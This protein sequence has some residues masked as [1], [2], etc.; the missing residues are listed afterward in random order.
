MIE[1]AAL[2]F[3]LGARIDDRRLEGATAE[4]NDLPVAGV[5]AR[6]MDERA[7]DLDGLAS[8]IERAGNRNFV[9]AAVDR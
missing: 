5:G 1:A 6:K 7:G 9:L 4:A 2:G 3:G 8:V